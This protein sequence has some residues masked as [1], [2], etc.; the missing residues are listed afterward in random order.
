M[1]IRRKAFYT[2]KIPKQIKLKGK[3][4]DIDY[5]WGLREE[6]ELL[7]GLCIFK[8]RKILLRR[9]LLSVEK[10]SVFLHEFIHAVIYESHLLAH[11]GDTEQEVLCDAIAETLLENFTIKP[12]KIT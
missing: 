7:D 6:N 2:M 8:D 5:K 12:K 11:I 3:T 1:L 4:W 10:P 9:E